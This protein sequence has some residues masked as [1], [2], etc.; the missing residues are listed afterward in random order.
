M[1]VFFDD[2]QSVKLPDG[3]ED[4]LVTAIDRVLA[5]EK[6]EGDYE[7]SLS[8][9]SP[10][11]IR[12]LNALYR[13]KDQVTDVLSFPADW[14]IRL[15]VQPLGDIVLC[16]LRAQEQADTIGNTLRQELMY[17]TVHSVLHLLGYDHMNPQDKERM[18]E[19][20]RQI[21]AE[22]ER[23]DEEKGTGF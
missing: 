8:F 9:V 7:L 19:K 5:L 1:T 23:S 15:P 13:N 16:P 17:L 20:E 21:V 18:R 12:E 6:Q 4:L 22:M 10:E 2:R 14:E 11:E 3:I